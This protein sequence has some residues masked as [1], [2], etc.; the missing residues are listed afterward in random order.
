MNSFGMIFY[1]HWLIKDSTVLF[2]TIIIITAIYC[3]S[4]LYLFFWYNSISELFSFN[5]EVVK[6]YFIFIY[7]MDKPFLCWP[8]NIIFTR[9]IVQSRKYSYSPSRISI[10]CSIGLR[11]NKLL[12]LLALSSL[13]T[14]Y[15]T[16][17]DTSIRNIIV[18]K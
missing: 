12:H 6:C 3:N 9:L 15:T 17:A 10:K 7:K 4:F 11:E 14:S 5:L 8:N 18:I 16:G 1:K 13:I 2:F